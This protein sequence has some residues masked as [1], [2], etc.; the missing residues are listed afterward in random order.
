MKRQWAMF[1]LGMWLCGS[2][3]VSFVATQNF[4]TVDRLLTGSQNA[5]FQAEVHTIG[6]PVAREFLRYLSSELNRLYFLVW[7]YAQ[8]AIGTLT[9]LM[10]SGSPSRW[11]RRVVIA[12]LA[13]VVLMTFYLQPQITS[14]GRS[15]DF[16]PREPAP[17]GMSRFWMLH[18]AYTALELAK[19]TAALVAGW[20]VARPVEGI[21]TPIG[22]RL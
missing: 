8:I 6:S 7:N 5:E 13:I 22:E 4:H 1:L 14:L 2:L 21:R 11:A 9:L 15:L 17:P 10:L 12:M 18:G 3:A 19:L 16:V 20:L